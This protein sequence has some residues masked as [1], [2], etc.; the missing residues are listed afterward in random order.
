MARDIRAIQTRYKGHRFRSRL[1]ARWAVFLDHLG[2]PWEYER[3]GYELPNGDR[4]LPDFWLPDEQ[5]HIEIKGQKPNA[6][7]TLK[8]AQLACISERPVYLLSGGL[9]DYRVIGYY[10]LHL[11]TDP[12]QGWLEHMEREMPISLRPHLA[13]RES[14]LTFM[15]YPGINLPE[16]YATESENLLWLDVDPTSGQ[17]AVWEGAEEADGEEYIDRFGRVRVLDGRRKDEFC[18]FLHKVGVRKPHGIL[19]MREAW[20]P[21]EPSEAAREAIAAALSARFEFG[22]SG[23]G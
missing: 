3:E 21:Q 2:I 10:G 9:K 19:D 4:Y 20:E 5:V 14:L 13:I 7:E 18:L 16:N 15:A 8:A 17:L 23:A 12:E 1:E 11:L 6:S 22:E